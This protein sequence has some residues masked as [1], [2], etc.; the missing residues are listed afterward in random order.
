VHNRPTHESRHDTNAAERGRM[1]K[2]L[3]VSEMLISWV[4]L[5]RFAVLPL[6]LAVTV[7]A[8]AQ[9][10]PVPPG[11]QP[12]IHDQTQ[13]V[14]R[15]VVVQQQ[16][17]APIAQPVPVPVGYNPFGYYQD[18]AYGA[19]TGLSNV[20]NAQGQ[21]DIQQEQARLLREK[22]RQAQLDT[23]RKMQD[24]LYY[25]QDRARA[26]AQQ[27]ASQD[28]SDLLQQ[29]RESP[30]PTSIWSGDTL[31][32]LIDNIR[33]TQTNYGVRGAP[34]PL[35]QE[36][37]KFINVTTGAT[38]YGS[39]GMFRPGRP[40]R[41]PLPLQEDR[42]N[43]YRDAIEKQAAGAVGAVVANKPAGK[44]IRDLQAAIGQLKSDLGAAAKEMTPT[45]YIKSMR[46]ANQLNEAAKTLTDPNAVLLL[47]GTWSAQGS[48][49]GE[50]IAYLGQNGLRIAPGDEGSEP[51]YSG[52]YR[53]ILNYDM[54]LVR[55]VSS[56]SPGGQ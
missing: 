13:G 2:Q 44:A 32:L 30:T 39:V 34:V 54:S 45:D 35:N 51:F 47:N 33:L 29:A 19:L 53:S 14:V 3:E 16:V 22:A 40:L 43:G 21:Y 7:A 56:P 50:M 41:W 20:V 5:R 23:R 11:Q 46:F 9:F 4:R 12:P 10:Q 17:G 28:R 1:N 26:R 48:T 15:P 37:L 27:Q 52:L 25:E 18:P 8:Q 42:W 6:A 36:G 55:L 31:N 49:V 38:S 24:D